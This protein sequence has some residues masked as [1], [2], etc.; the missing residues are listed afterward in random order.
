V[1]TDQ[2]QFCRD[3]GDVEMPGARDALQADVVDVASGVARDAFDPL[4]GRRGRKQ[5]NRID[6]RGTGSAANSADSSGG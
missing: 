3:A 2:R 6:A 4:I 5:E 1:A